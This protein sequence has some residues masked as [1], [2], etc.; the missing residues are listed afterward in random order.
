MYT[1]QF[2]SSY[3]IHMDITRVISNFFTNC[4]SHLNWLF[5]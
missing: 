4:I 3:F 2:I 5:L 1:V